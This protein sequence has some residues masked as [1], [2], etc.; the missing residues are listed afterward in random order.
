M[1]FYNIYEQLFLLVAHGLE[2]L[3]GHQY[4]YGGD[5][6]SGTDDN[7]SPAHDKWRA[8]N[9]LWLLV[10]EDV[11]LTIKVRTAECYTVATWSSH[12]EN[13]GHKKRFK[14]QSTFIII[15]TNI[16]IFAHL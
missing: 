15:D 11:T 8:N 9:G 10:V 14:N 2:L 12:R 16:I 13:S 5:H 1:Y 6:L 7:D 3:V 4:A